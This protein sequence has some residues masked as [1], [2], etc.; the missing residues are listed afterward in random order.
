MILK[1]DLMRRV[2]LKPKT[3]HKIQYQLFKVYILKWT[4]GSKSM[5]NNVSAMNLNIEYKPLPDSTT[6]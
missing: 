4:E 2:K 6:E 5:K 1:I 3:P